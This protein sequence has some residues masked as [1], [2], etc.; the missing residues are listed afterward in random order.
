MTMLEPDEGWMAALSPSSRETADA[1][2]RSKTVR[3]DLV[4][5]VEAWVG[6]VEVIGRVTSD[7][8][9]DDYACYVGW[10]EYLDAVMAALPEPDAAIVRRAIEPADTAFR[11]CTIDDG[12][13]AMSRKLNIKTDLWYWR[14]VPV[15]GPI[16]QSLGI[17]TT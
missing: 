5:L 17:G 2:A 16:A 13:A 8:Y 15:K 11:D 1:V 12:G 7:K 10:R 3:L 9:Y 14:R 4:A 6:S